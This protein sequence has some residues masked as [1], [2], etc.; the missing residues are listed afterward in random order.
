MGPNNE[1]SGDNQQS[2]E[3]DNPFIAFRR[4][5]DEQM[6]SL[7]HSFIGL[8][9]SYSSPNRRSRWGPY[10][11]EACRRARD[12][13]YASAQNDE[14]KSWWRPAAERDGS[15]DPEGDSKPLGTSVRESIERRAEDTNGAEAPVCPY[16][17]T[18]QQPQDTLHPNQILLPW[19][20]NYMLYS[21]YSPYHLERD[22]K[23]RVYGS[24]WK[25]AFQDLLDY[26]NGNTDS[27]E[28]ERSNP[29]NRPSPLRLYNESDPVSLPDIIRQLREWATDR[30]RRHDPWFE[31]LGSRQPE[32]DAGQDEMTELDLYER[33]W[34]RKRSERDDAL[35]PITNTPKATEAT[36]PDAHR[37]SSQANGSGSLG[38]IS[39][40]TSTERVTLPDGTVHTKVM[41][42]KRF[43][44]GREESSETVHTTQSGAQ[45]HGSASAIASGTTNSTEFPNTH[46]DDQ[47]G[48]NPKSGRKGWFWS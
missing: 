17:P 26:E 18:Q 36:S 29:E 8:P 2:Y 45:Q 4:Y 43:A 38:I 20:V 40:M 21:P 39:T 7:L 19:P 30:S 9:S 37:G 47:K 28:T 16:R 25:N 1:R 15:V 11:D 3:E 44:D 10:D 42:K 22:E 46:P 34:G 12:N 31:E 5:A 35:S 48:A 32:H 23:T 6:A 27:E 33:L 14:G 13:W 41:L 24:K